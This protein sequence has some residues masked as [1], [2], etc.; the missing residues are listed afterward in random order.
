MSA[1]QIKSACN[2]DKAIYRSNLQDPGI[3][4]KS[5]VDQEA[6]EEFIRSL[7]KD[8]TSNPKELGNCN[9]W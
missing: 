9:K 6:N 2:W 4:F 7:A 3:Q 8:L 5:K 1:A